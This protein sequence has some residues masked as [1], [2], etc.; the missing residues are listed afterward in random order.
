MSL[1]ILNNYKY[2]CEHGLSWMNKVHRFINYSVYQSEQKYVLT[3]RFKS[4]TNHTPLVICFVH[5]C[6]LEVKVLTLKK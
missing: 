1:K 4:C 5:Y 3:L 6:I 2:H